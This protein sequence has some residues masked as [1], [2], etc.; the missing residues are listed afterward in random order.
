MEIACEGVV[1]QLATSRITAQLISQEHPSPTAGMFKMSRYAIAL[2]QTQRHQISQGRYCASGRTDFQDIG[3]LLAVPA[4]V[5]VEIRSSGGPVRAVRCLFDRDLIEEYGAG[6]CVADG[7]LPASCLNLHQQDI[8]ATLTRMGHELRSPGLAGPALVETLG[9]A[10]VI[11][12]LRYLDDQPKGM[13]V[14]RGGLSRRQLR[15]ITEFIEAPEN[16]P[17]LSDLSSLTG[18]S[19]RH[20]TRAFKQTTGI[21][22]HSH[23]EQVR[24]QKAQALLA[25]TDVMVKGIARRLG[26]SCSGAFSSAFRRLAGETPQDYRKRVRKLGASGSAADAPV[27][28]VHLAA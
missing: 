8:A 17:T 3:R 22:V 15:L 24:F 1:A 13:P 25:D 12:L 27:N 2:Q 10:I 20:L 16:C 23:I 6:D 5:P 9:T 26:F 18:L 28:Q 11:E 19:I 21:T 7:D 4:G 14:Y